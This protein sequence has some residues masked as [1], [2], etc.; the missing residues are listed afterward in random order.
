MTSLAALIASLRDRFAAVGVSSPQVDAELLV[1]SVLGIGRGELLAEAYRGAEVDDDNVQALEPLAVRREKR[2]PLQHL[3][4]RA[5]F[6]NFEL[7][8]GPGVFVPRPETETVAERAIGLLQAMGVGDTEVAVLD[9]CSGSG[10]LAIALARGVPWATV[11][12][13]EASS[14]AFE[15]LV[16]NVSLLA[17]EVACVLGTVAEFS[18][19]VADKS[20]DMVVANPPYVP[21]AEVPNDP[22]VAHYDPPQA[23][24]GGVDGLD[25]VREIATLARRGLRSG[26]VVIMEHSNLQGEQVA[27]LLRDEGF[28]AVHTEV[29]L[30]GRDRFTHA[31]AP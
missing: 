10:A 25:V 3:L 11:T 5:P 28:R 16:S 21:I 17:P 19:G 4:G 6:M 30:L 9:A 8:V 24:Y 14:E 2:E 7:S 31:L 22:E 18:P 26:G 12:A 27:Q 13:L 23:L 29:D 15:Y 20:L 1:A